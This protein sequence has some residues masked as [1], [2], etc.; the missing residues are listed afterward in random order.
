MLDKSQITDIETLPTTQEVPTR[1]LTPD[2]LL[3]KIGK[4][5][6]T[7]SVKATDPEGKDSSENLN[8]LADLKLNNPVKFA[9]FFDGLKLS[10]SVKT[11]LEKMIDAG[12]KRMKA[13]ERAEKERAG[14]SCGCGECG[15]GESEK[16][17][18]DLPKEETEFD[19]RVNAKVKEVIES[20]TTYEYIYNVWQQRVKGNPLLGRALICS[21]GVQSCTNTKGLHIW[22]QGKPG[23]GKSHGMEVMVVL[24]PED[25]VKDGDVSPKVLYYMQKNGLILPG[26]T[27]SID[28][29]DLKGELAVLF[30]KM[31]TRFQTG[32][33]QR[34]VIDGE[35][36]EL[37]MPPRL[38]IW[39]SSVDMQ[40]DEQ[41]RDRFLSVPIDEKQTTAIIDFMKGKDKA[42]QNDDDK[43]FENAVCRGLF[44]DLA[45]KTF[46]VEIPFA[47]DFEFQTTEGTRGY[48]IFSDLIKGLTALRYAKRETNDQGHLLAL[49]EDFYGAKTI[50]ES[51]M[52][53][54]E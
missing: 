44:S 35:V 3:Q 38:A 6:K 8:V 21:R 52:G 50:Y 5:I 13:K 20:G 7:D 40:G 48:G 15:C 33:E 53:H 43:K 46:H 29:M 9:V 45:S 4:D 12:V 17:M 14:P 16:P 22:A 36:F 27:I 39:T 1:K 18:K 19:K 41:L 24:L 47:D 31:T 51:L 28:E 23:Q 32:A 42:P 54:S 11:G 26:T 10:K 37:K 49:P 25:H 30:K 2:E 34:V